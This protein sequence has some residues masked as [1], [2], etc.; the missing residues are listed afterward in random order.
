LIV[1]LFIF[2]AFIVDETICK[3]RVLNQFKFHNIY[4]LKNKIGL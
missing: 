1:R 2:S 3:I 4:M